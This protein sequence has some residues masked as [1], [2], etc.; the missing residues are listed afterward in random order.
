MPPGSACRSRYF[1]PAES[2]EPY[3]LALSA[4]TVLASSILLAARYAPRIVMQLQVLRR[5]RRCLPQFG[6]RLVRLAYLRQRSPSLPWQSVH[7]GGL[8]HLLDSASVGRQAHLD[9]G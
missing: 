4:S 3:S 2:F 6:D 7:C 8:P 5:E 9:A 1:G